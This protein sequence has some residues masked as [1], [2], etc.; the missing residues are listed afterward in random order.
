MAVSATSWTSSAAV[1][2]GPGG[3]SIWGFRRQYWGALLLLA[4]GCSGLYVLL[5]YRASS[6]VPS[7]ILRHFQSFSTRVAALSSEASL[8]TLPHQEAAWGLTQNHRWNLSVLTSLEALRD[9]IA[10]SSAPPLL[11]LFSSWA[12]RPDLGLVR[13]L[14]LRNWAQLRPFVQPVL[15]TN[16]SSLAEQARAHGWQTLPVSREAVGVPI[17]KNM[18]LDAMDRLQL[19][20]V[21]LRQRRRAV[22]ALAHSNLAGHTDVTTPPVRLAARACGW[23]ARQRQ[24]GDCARDRDF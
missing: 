3:G 9:A 18:Y 6:S 13:N 23:H 7:L 5:Y 11:T 10:N 16:S 1:V 20:A 12:D 22:H 4:A 19:H 14:T 15:F 8:P 24:Y 21:R 2:G 17:L